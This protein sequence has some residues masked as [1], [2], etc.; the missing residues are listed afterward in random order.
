MTEK[1]K[2]LAATH[3][4]ILLSRLVFCKNC[5]DRNGTPCTCD[6][7]PIIKEQHRLDACCKEEP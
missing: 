2:D 1:E 5:P 4:A 3:V 6:K 7:C